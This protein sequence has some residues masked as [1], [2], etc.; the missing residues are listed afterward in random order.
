MDLHHKTIVKPC[1]YGM[2]VSFG[3]NASLDIMCL[4][5]VNVRNAVYMACLNKSPIQPYRW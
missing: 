5:N 3:M 2:N 4:Y 1:G